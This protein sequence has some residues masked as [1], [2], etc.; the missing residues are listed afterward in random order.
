MVHGHIVPSLSPYASYSAAD[1][2]RAAEAQH[3]ARIESAISD[4]IEAAQCGGYVDLADV[5]GDIGFAYADVTLEE[6]LEECPGVTEHAR[7]RPTPLVEGEI[8]VAS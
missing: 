3:T 5:W 7:W 8:E 6:V 4:V 1:Q 2:D